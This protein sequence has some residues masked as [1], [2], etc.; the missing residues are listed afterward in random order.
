MVSVEVQEV[1]KFKRFKGF[2]MKITTLPVALGL[3]LITAGTAFGNGYEF[4]APT[5][6]DN[7]PLDLVY[8]GQIR[9]KSTGKIIR[10]PAYLMVT[11]KETGMTFPFGNDRPGHF[12]SPDVG[13]HIKDLGG[14]ID[15]D[16]LEIELVVDGYKP[17]KITRVPR[18]TT[19]VIEVNFALEPVSAAAAAAYAPAETPSG[20]GAPA[21]GGGSPFGWYAFVAGAVALSI[22]GAAARTLGPRSSTAR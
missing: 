13:Q 15:A 8:V 16:D 6:G 17:T 12:R 11:E 18:R 4:F 14:K 20:D 3:T 10:T 1:Q 22:A 9:D 21:G 7:R 2:L 19:G 5:G